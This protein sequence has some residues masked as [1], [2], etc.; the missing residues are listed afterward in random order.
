MKALIIIDVQHDF[1]PGGS[2]AVPGGDAIIQPILALRKMFDL[3]VFTQDWH[4]ANHSS[5]KEYGG[6]WP[7]HCVQNSH[8]AEIEKSLLRKDD[9]VVR[10]GTLQEV[11]S[12]SG[13]WDNERKHKTGLDAL[14]KARSIDTVYV[15]GLATDYCVKFTVLDAIESGYTVHLMADACRGVDANKGDTQRA[16][17]EM[18][19]S[20]AIVVSSETIVQ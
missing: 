6:I 7:I 17:V 1:L 12:Y 8:G 10:K 16:V 3:T 9:I 13:F 4:P 2:L 19:N 5:F 20:G 15:C 14:L 18:K 11:D